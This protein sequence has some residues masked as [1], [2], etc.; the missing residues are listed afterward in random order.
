MPTL[1]RLIVAI[2]VLAG[3]AYGAMVALVT[4]EK[5]TQREIVTPVIL[6]TPA[7]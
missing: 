2:L 6:P 1:T 4:F 3:L 5:P 7:K